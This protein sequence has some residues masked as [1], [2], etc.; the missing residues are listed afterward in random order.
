MAEDSGD[1]FDTPG[2]AF[3]NAAKRVKEGRYDAID[4]F[5]N[6]DLIATLSRREDG[7]VGVSFDPFWYGGDDSP[8]PTNHGKPS[9]RYVYRDGTMVELPLNRHDH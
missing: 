1:R 2:E 7:S 9:H 3:Y 6:T 8:P 4:V 5:R